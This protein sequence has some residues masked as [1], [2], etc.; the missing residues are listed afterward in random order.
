MDNIFDHDIE[1]IAKNLI[2]TARVHG[3]NFLE[4]W[5]LHTPI[6][7]KLNATYEEVMKYIADNPFS[8]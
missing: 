5:D 4:A 8:L 1:R 2:V 3:C 6:T 7:V